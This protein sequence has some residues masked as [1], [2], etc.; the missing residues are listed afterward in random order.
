MRP[1][2]VFA[3]SFEAMTTITVKIVGQLTGDTEFDSPETIDALATEAATAA[4]PRT[5]PGT[6]PHSI[7]GL[8]VLLV[9][10]LVAWRWCWPAGPIWA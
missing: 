5:L 7:G 3:K 9:V 8:L 1:V 2:T 6:L 4:D 10:M